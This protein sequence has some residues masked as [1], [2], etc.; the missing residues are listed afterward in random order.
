MKP[1]DPNSKSHQLRL[2]LAGAARGGQLPFGEVSRLA[3]EF[4]V[5]RQ[6]VAQV[7]SGLDLLSASRTRQAKVRKR[8][9]CYQCLCGQVS[10]RKDLC[11]A[12][13]RIELLCGRCGATVLRTPGQMIQS[14]KIQRGDTVRVFCGGVCATSWAG[15]ASGRQRRPARET[16]AQSNVDA[17]L[18]SVASDGRLPWGS[19]SRIARQLG[20][21]Q[22]FVRSRV[23]NLRL[24]RQAPC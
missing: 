18:R 8:V 2:S 12:C 17:A 24:N 9:P 6:L 14:A 16:A 10:T 1:A 22:S 5:S 3:K 23:R 13:R 21:S 7:K 15:A 11:T 4:G 19:Q 20:V